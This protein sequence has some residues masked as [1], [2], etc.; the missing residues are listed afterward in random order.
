VN[1][2]R[3]SALVLS[4][5]AV[6]GCG[7]SAVKASTPTASVAKGAATTVSAAGG[8]GTPAKSATTK[9]SAARASGS[10]DCAAVKSAAAGVIVNWQLVA[11]LPR[12]TDVA[13]WAEMS[14]SIGTLSQFASQLATLQTQLGSDAD[15]AKAL[16]FMQSANE[17]VQK[18]VAGDASAP[19]QLSKQ[20]G[21]DLTAI[22]MKQSPITMAASAAH[23]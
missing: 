22:L 17:I 20:L 11:Q 10:V 5:V 16:S 4:A 15:A 3:S 8:T 2:V 1:V 7:S 18:G 13:R 23:C 6:V 21:T 19:A 14:K 12:E 9:A